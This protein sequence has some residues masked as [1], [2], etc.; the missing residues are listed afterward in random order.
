MHQGPD[1]EKHGLI[2]IRA[3]EVIQIIAHYTI[4]IKIYIS[5]NIEGFSCLFF[6][7][8]YL[9]LFLFFFFAY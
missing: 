4:F 7:Y 5:R 1:S 6:I 2:V 3:A 8:D 9:V